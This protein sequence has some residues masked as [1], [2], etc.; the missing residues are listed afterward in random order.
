MQVGIGYFPGYSSTRMRF[1]EMR[2]AATHAAFLL[3]HLEPGQYLLDFGCGT[4]SITNDLACYVGESGSVVGVDKELGQCE[5]AQKAA[6]LGAIGNV[7]Y[8]CRDIVSEGLEFPDDTFDVVFT[9]AV[10]LHLSDPKMALREMV[11][12]L[13]P[14]G[15]LALSEPGWSAKMFPPSPAFE[16]CFQHYQALIKASGGDP[17]IAPGLLGYLAELKLVDTVQSSSV[18]V[19]QGKEAVEKLADAIIKHIE[20]EGERGGILASQYESEVKRSI[21]EVRAWLATDAWAVTERWFECIC[22]K[23]L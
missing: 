17:D 13:R 21:Q 19:H 6:H 23:P 11:R 2:R 10:L 12:V 15:L 3:P 4:G 20:D 7:A 16:R 5:R 9:H 22:R 8:L 1:Q 18:E 14:G